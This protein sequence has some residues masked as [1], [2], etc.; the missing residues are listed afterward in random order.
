MP[1]G[2][3]IVSSAL[4]IALVACGGGGTSSSPPVTGGPAPTPTPTSTTGT[5]CTVAE[6]IDF[7]D[8]VLNEWYLFPDLLDD[9]VDPDDF[10][11]VQDFLNARVAPARAAQRDVGFTFATSIAEENAL[12][13]SGSSAGFG[14]RLSYDTDNDRVF[15]LEAFENGNAFASGFDRSSELLAIGE[16][17]GSLQLVSDL[18]ASGG[19]SAV[20]DA[21]GPSTAG[22]ERVLRFTEPGGNV[23]ETVVTKSD[24]D[25]DPISDRY[26]ALILDDGGKRVGYLNLRT[27]IV[28]TSDQ[29]LVDAF[30]EFSNEGIDEIILDFR[31]N[32]GGLVR[33]AE[34]LGDLL[35]G[36]NTGNVFSRTEL[37]PSKSDENETR[38]FQATARLVDPQTGD[39][40]NSVSLPSIAPMKIAL[41][42][43]SSTASASELVTNSMIPYVATNSL[44]LIGGNTSGKPVGQF[45]FDLDRCDLRVRAVTFQTVNANGDGEY[46]TGLAD[47]IPNTCRAEDDF[48]TPL[49]DPSEASIAT[50]LDFLAGRSCTA[51]SGGGITAQSA[52]RRQILQ[53][54]R[55]NAVQYENPGVF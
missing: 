15:V 43:T 37:R 32:G 29:Q 49:G 1:I 5:A 39:L 42:G 19:P 33:I 52:N 50:A 26:G 51:I 11:D 3:T 27:F 7:A 8:A 9:T 36:P 6:E 21:L 54:S 45:G 25:L 22:L 53:P 38:F 47:V 41:I 46:F 14:I 23:V 40:G 12:I 48:S 34:L 17:G 35:R 28:G 2:R 10:D 55:P 16:P 13:A 30:T 24:F 18:M 20:I 44:G 31:Y 4:A